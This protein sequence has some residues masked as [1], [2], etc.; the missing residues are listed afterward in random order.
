MHPDRATR[1][2]T[3]SL[4]SLAARAQLGDRGALERL[5]RALEVPLLAHV[6]TI[7]DD[8]D[9]ADDV[10]QEVLLKISRGLGSLRA[11]D[12]VRAWAYRITTRE[13][14]RVARAERHQRH[15]AVVDWDDLPAAAGEDVFAPDDAPGEILARLDALPRRAQLVLR[16][17][18]LEELSQQ[19]IAE[20]LEIPLGTVKSR[21]A[22]GLSALRRVTSRGA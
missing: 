17:R 6:N 19:E 13:A 8:R 1:A 7:V 10:L 22:Y 16:M 11:P 2:K 15:E 5:L 12:W 21:I 9:L 3:E 14:I 18:Y 20:A 4:P